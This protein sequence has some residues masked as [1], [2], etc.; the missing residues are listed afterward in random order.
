MVA[1]MA[2]WIMKPNQIQITKKLFCLSLSDIPSY[3]AGMGKFAI[4]TDSR[5]AQL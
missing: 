3:T 4:V 1:N 5:M 2:I